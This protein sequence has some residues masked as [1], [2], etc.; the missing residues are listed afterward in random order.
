MFWGNSEAEVSQEDWE[1]FNKYRSLYS[2]ECI[3]NSPEYCRIKCISI[4]TIV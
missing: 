3:L 2:E 1:R 4:I